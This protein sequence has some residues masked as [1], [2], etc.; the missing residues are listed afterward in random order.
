MM[1]GAGVMDR[2]R[3]GGRMVCWC[4]GDAEIGE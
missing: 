1:F 2:R 3:E 4:A